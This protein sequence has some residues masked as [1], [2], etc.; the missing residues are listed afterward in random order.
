MNPVATFGGNVDYEYLILGAGPAGLQMG[1]HL[2]RAGHSYLILEAGDCPGYFFKTFPRHR[3]LISSNKVYTGSEE[4]IGEQAV[5]RSPLDPVG[6]VFV[7][8]ALWR[9]VAD[10][11]AA[12][13]VGDRVVVEKV[14]GLTLTVRKAT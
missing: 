10:D 5:V 1:H 11:S 3:T 6:H 9:A 12:L 7:R 4:L 2:S 13:Q 14:E 8:G